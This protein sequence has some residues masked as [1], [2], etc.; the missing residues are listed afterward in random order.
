MRWRWYYLKRTLRANRVLL[1]VLFSFAVLALILWNYREGMIERFKV[2]FHMYGVQAAGKTMEELWP[3]LA[4]GEK[5]KEPFWTGFMKKNALFSFLEDLEEP[6]FSEDPAYE[7]LLAQA[8]RE[9][10]QNGK[11]TNG[12]GNQWTSGLGGNGAANSADAGPGAGNLNAEADPT[13]GAGQSAGA[14]QYAEAGQSAGAGQNAGGSA[15]ENGEAKPQ[16]DL[17]AGA[18]AAQ[19]LAAE[20]IASKVPGQTVIREK[21]AD[22]DY[23]MN[24]FYSVHPTTTAGRDL[25]NVDK[26][27]NMDFT[28]E[29]KEGPQILIYH[30]HSQEEFADYPE[31]PEATI[32]GVGTYLTELLETKGYHVIHD[33]GVYDLH[34]GKLDRSKAYTYALDGIT[35]ILQKYP[36]IEVVLDVHRDGVKAG[37]RLVKEIDGKPTAQIMFFNGTSQTPDGPIEYLPNP[38]RDFNLGFSF[39]MQ[40]AAAEKY[41]GYT[42]KIYLKGLRYNEHV[43]ARAAL[44]EVGAQTNTYEEARNAMIPLAEILDEVLAGE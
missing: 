15:G 43:R 6:E 30:T 34:D 17:A 28:I 44:I 22:Y 35:G 2:A 12:A 24:S 11:G 29:K 38:N 19:G 5:E 36:S 42:R 9:R 21:L 3:A 32:V 20:N 25:M 7:K 10:M 31:N 33:T 14:G 37:T 39:Q 16:T 8:W 18:L 4:G 40:L 13:G 26:F 41:P 1:P 23:L 27:L